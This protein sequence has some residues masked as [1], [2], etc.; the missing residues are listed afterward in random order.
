VIE[1]GSPIGREGY[2]PDEPDDDSLAVGG[3]IDAGEERCG[4]ATGAAVAGLADVRGR[5][6]RQFRTLIL[7][8]T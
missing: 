3:R 6:N 8:P 5:G 7:W 2:A 4:L 1:P